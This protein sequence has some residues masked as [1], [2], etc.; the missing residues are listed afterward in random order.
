MPLCFI[1][2]GNHF[3]DELQP[4]YQRLAQYLKPHHKVLIIPFA[5]EPA[6]YDG[7]HRTGIQTFQAFGIDHVQLLPYDLSSDDMIAQINAHDVLY[8][9]GGRPDRLME[10]LHTKGLVPVLQSFPDL[11]IGYSAGALAFSRDCLLSRYDDYPQTRVIPGLGLVPFSVDVHYHSEKDEE[12]MPL[13]TTTPLY[14]IPDGAAIFWDNDKMTTV[15]P[16][17]A[18]HNGNKERMP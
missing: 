6:K 15:N 16:I 4:I 8:L 18:F 13:S 5:T 9:I 14:A 2:G 3:N 11:M 1:G 7:W 10:R 12:L 17:T